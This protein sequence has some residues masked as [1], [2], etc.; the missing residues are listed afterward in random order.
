MSDIDDLIEVVREKSIFVRSIL[1]LLAGES[2]FHFDLASTLMSPK[3]SNLVARII[4]EMMADDDVDYIGGL[5]MGAL[6]ISV[7]VVQLSYGDRPIKGFNMREGQKDHGMIVKRFEGALDDKLIRGSRVIIVEDVTDTGKH[8][9]DAIGRV[10]FAGGTVVRAIT[11]LD[12]LNG[13]T[14][15]LRDEG[16]ELRAFMT[17]LSFGIPEG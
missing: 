8:V 7:C 15:R 2:P 10:R 1:T 3:G 6:M 12:R 16:I 4:Y 13:A 5:G 17:P 11:I 14:E 9:L